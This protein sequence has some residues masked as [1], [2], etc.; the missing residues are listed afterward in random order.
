LAAEAPVHPAFV[1]TLHQLFMMQHVILQISNYF[2][3]QATKF[4]ARR[5]CQLSGIATPAWLCPSASSDHSLNNQ[6]WLHLIS[7]EP[8]AVQLSS[9]LGEM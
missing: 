1:I 4:P 2:P 8:W 7:F 6:T 3:E 9:S 5:R